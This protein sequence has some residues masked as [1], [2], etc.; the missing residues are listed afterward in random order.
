MSDLLQGEPSRSE[1]EGGAK[2]A[3]TA[4]GGAAASS[5][6]NGV[7]AGAGRSGDGAAAA[8]APKPKRGRA[9]KPRA[10]RLPPPEGKRVGIRGGTRSAG[11]P[12]WTAFSVDGGF[13]EG[14]ASSSGEPYAAASD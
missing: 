3:S 1:S 13:W 11:E 5:S 4:G 12:N 7:A 2:A 9:L 14:H 6:S 8:P 10:P